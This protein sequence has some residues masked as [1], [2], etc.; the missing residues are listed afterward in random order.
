LGIKARNQF[1]IP[2]TARYRLPPNSRY[3]EM[4]EG[5][6]ETVA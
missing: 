6:T 4:I 5:Q 2:T 3:R 1:N